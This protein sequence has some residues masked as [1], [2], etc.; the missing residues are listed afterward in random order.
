M[1]SP[2]QRCE[3]SPKCKFLHLDQSINHQWICINPLHFELF[4]IFFRYAFS[5]CT[6]IFHL[7]HLE[8]GWR[9]GQKTKMVYFPNS[10]I[11]RI[12]VIIVPMH[13][14][15]VFKIYWCKL[16]VE[17]INGLGCRIIPVK[18]VAQ[19]LRPD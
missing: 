4:R 10:N 6:T 8:P 9:N 2:A 12:R 11:W 16:F 15:R 1:A 3:S 13:A 17:I 19:S 14:N 7:R 18:L 5:I